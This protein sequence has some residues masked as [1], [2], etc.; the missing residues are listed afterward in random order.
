MSLSLVLIEIPFE[1]RLTSNLIRVFISYGF[2]VSA[3][4]LIWWIR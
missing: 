3:L 2:T 1:G 4:P